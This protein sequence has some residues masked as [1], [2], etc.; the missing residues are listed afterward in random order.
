MIKNFLSTPAEQKIYSLMFWKRTPTLTENS[1]SINACITSTHY[2][3]QA[4]IYQAATIRKTLILNKYH[5]PREI[6]GNPC[7]LTL[8]KV[9]LLSI[10]T[11]HTVTAPQTIRFWDAFLLGLPNEKCLGYTHLTAQLLFSMFSS[12][13]TFNFDLILGCFWHQNGLILK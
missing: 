1:F 9:W 2:F 4:A 12:I 7:L 11:I 5:K 6:V 10:W 3:Y 13:L 8:V